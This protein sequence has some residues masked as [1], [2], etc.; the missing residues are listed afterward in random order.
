MQKDLQR[1]QMDATPD[2][3]NLKNT[4][5]PVVALTDYERTIEDSAFFVALGTAAGAFEA[6]RSRG[7]IY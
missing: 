3:C 7:C 2:V 1:G 5:N 4:L 6:D